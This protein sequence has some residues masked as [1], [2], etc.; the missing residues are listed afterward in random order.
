M[1]PAASS[2][3]PALISRRAALHRAAALLGFALSPSLVQ[4]VLRAQ[5]AAGG[6]RLPAAAERA[7]AALAERILPRTD[8]PGAADVGVPA[9]IGRMFEGFLTP[10]ERD[11]LTSGVAALDQAC[12]ARGGRAF[13][14]LDG[15]GQDDAIR[16]LA[17]AQNESEREFLRL[18]R[19]LVIVGYFT[20]EQVG[21]KL[22]RYDPVPGRY[23]ADIPLAETGG[24]AWNRP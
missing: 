15:A 21:R 23:D 12:A 8:T 2:T 13:A 17:A 22:L 1:N 5:P 10:A 14:D 6:P 11:R 18:V 19:E 16:G 24:A 4:G 9:F 3:D 7:L 20:S